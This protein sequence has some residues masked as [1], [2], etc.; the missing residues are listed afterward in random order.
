MTCFALVRDIGVRSQ[1]VIVFPVEDL[2]PSLIAFDIT[3]A[4][5]IAPDR[6]R[7]CLIVGRES[8]AGSVG[9]FAARDQLGRVAQKEPE[10]S[11]RVRAQGVVSSQNQGLATEQR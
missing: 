5:Q 7:K 3:V 8:P 6:H 2:F 1:S 4:W 11:V 10:P 9:R